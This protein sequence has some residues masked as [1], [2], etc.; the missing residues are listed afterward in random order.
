MKREASYRE[1]MR[2]WAKT[3]TTGGGVGAIPDIG[4]GMGPGRGVGVGRTGG[5]DIG[6]PA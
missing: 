2:L 4:G 3:D 5:A 6:A 1:A